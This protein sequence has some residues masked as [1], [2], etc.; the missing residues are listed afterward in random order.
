MGCGLGQ[1]HAR[2]RREFNASSLRRSLMRLPGEAAV[3]RGL[4]MP[5]LGEYPG[6]ARA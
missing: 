1:W 6:V 4:T 2:E 3:A 5:G